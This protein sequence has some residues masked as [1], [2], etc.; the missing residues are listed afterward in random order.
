MRAWFFTETAY[1]YLPPQD[2]FESI[3]VQLPN[4]IFDPHKGADLYHR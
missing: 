3:R 1:P 4:G 2:E